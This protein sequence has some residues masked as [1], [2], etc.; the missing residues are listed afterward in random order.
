MVKIRGLFRKKFEFKMSGNPRRHFEISGNA[1]SNTVVEIKDIAEYFVTIVDCS[2]HFLNF[3]LR[4]GLGKVSFNCID[5]V[6]GNAR[7]P[8]CMTDGFAGSITH[9]IVKRTS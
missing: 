1:V 3:I 6:R 4:P 5:R 9:F 8:I 7:Q 2:C